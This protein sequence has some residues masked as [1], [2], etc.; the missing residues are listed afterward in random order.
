[1]Q[2]GSLVGFG[3]VFLALTW[4]ASAVACAGVLAAA[5]RLRAHGPLVERTAATLALLLPP[6]LAASATGILAGSSWFNPTDHCASHGHHLHL[7]LHHGGAWA[8][9]TGIALA[10]LGAGLAVAVRTVWLLVRV[11]RAPLAM[12]RLLAVAE[13]AWVVGGIP[14]HLVPASVPFCFTTGLRTPRIYMATAAWTRLGERE[15]QAVLAHEMAHIRQRD[16]MQ[17]LVLAGLA[18]LGLPGL[19]GS[20]RQL[21]HRATE[22]LCDRHA[23]ADVGE[24]ATVASALLQLVVSKPDEA[25][26]LALAFGPAC[27]VTERI[28]AVLA[29]GP[30]GQKQ[31]TLLTSAALAATTAT[32]LGAVLW[33]DPLHH[34]IESLLGG[35]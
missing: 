27:A 16:L 15:R 30:D 33:V 4:L 5:A 12:A 8:E 25:R 13:P 29:G 20:V 18:G 35:H 3:A 7:C 14:V 9:R 6:V 32:F 28:E 31:A 17:S 21:W 23:A 24:A 22:R 2:P 11:A 19:T 34:A 26:A 1:M 10:V